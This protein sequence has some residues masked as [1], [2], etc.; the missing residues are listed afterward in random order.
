[1]ATVVGTLLTV[2]W[3]T[4]EPETQPTS[5]PS[6]VVDRLCATVGAARANNRVEASRLYFDRTDDQVRQ[7]ADRT[8]D[9]DRAAA[10]RLREAEDRVVANLESPQPVLEDDLLTLVAA[11]RS[12]LRVLDD[13]VPAP[14][15]PEDENR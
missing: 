15:P 12:A 14:C 13:R 1:M 10:A 7:L 8:A 2:A 9:R 4:G 6:G 5:D 11:T 3:V